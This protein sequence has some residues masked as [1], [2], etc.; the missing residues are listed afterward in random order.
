M[1][2]VHLTELAGWL[3]AAGVTVVE[4][5]GWL[6][7][8]RSSGGFEP[9]RPWAVFW[10]HTAS[11]TSPENDASYCSYG[12]PDRPICN[13]L[14]CRDGTVW[15]LAAG[16]TNTNGKGGPFTVSRGTIPL[17]SANSYVIGVEIAN[18]GTGEPYPQAQID[19]AFTAS[20]TICQRLGLDPG[21]VC[22]HQVWAPT[23][24]VDP[25]TA[26]AVEG[27]WRPSST[28]GS[29]TWSLDDLRAEC[30]RR[31]AGGSTEGETDVPLTDDEITRIAAATAEAVWNTKIDSTGPDQIE[32][33][34]AKFLLHRAF[35]IVSQYLGSFGG[36]PPGD[37]RPSWLKQILDNTKR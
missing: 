10:H 25:A 30:R 15:V 8:A 28:T 3:R 9:G 20:V 13:L 7:R 4:Q 33:Q 32:P 17:D 34:P 27:P 26:A 24:K 18:G 11:V 37:Y 19:A 22:I 1:G 6:T 12:S 14:V 5:D 16:A 21:D 23:R 36:K 29:G 31:A 2:S 35:L